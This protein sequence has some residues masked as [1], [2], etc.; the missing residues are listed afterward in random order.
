[1]R[2]AVWRAIVKASTL[3]D[4]PDA[5]P[6]VTLRAV[7]ALTQAS[8]AYAKLLDAAEFDARLRAVEAHT[9]LATS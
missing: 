7:H 2:D 4:D 3:L 1:M 9:G 5:K 6:D 8:G